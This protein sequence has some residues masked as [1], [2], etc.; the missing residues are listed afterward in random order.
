M[1]KKKKNKEKTGVYYPDL[2]R[3]NITLKNR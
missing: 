3:I 2:L 1:K